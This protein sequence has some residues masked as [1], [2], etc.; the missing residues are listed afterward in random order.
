MVHMSPGPDGARLHSGMS[1]PHAILGF[2]G[3]MPMTGYDLKRQAFDVSVAHF[4]PAVLPQI[5]RE[6]GK[7][8]E[9]G[10]AVSEVELQRGKP[11]RRV[12]SITAT[13]RAELRR[14]LGEF[15][16]PV[17]YREPF[18]V[19]LFFAAHLTNAEI[20]M[21]LRAQREA[22]EDR[23]AELRAVHIP[24]PQDAI[25]ARWGALTGLTL[26]LGLRL[27]E[28]YLEWLDHAIRTV[29]ALEVDA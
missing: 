22:H 28:T 20:L 25:G 5:Y 4:W 18:L 26:D 24:L 7:L 9:A 29:A 11:N 2:L 1:L 8:E 6:L 27:E 13:G 3:I 23:R 14:W 19:Q 21:L 16:A 10:W 15:E 12:Y 17:R